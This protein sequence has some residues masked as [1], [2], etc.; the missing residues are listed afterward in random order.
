MVL[1]V[2]D[3]KY[4]FVDTENDALLLENNLIKVEAKV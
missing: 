1:R 3:I 2:A 4:I